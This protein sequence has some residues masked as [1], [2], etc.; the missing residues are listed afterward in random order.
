MKPRVLRRSCRLRP[1]KQP[2][3]SA[4]QRGEML[5]RARAAHVFT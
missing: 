3:S 5:E 4:L 1:A 2:V